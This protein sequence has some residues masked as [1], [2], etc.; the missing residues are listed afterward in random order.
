MSLR[1]IANWKLNG[2]KEF[3]QKWISNFFK[4]FNN[5]DFSSIGIAPPSMYLDHLRGLLGKNDICLGA[6]NIDEE[7]SG[8]RTGEISASMIKD[9][10]CEFSIVGHSERRTLFNESNQ[11]I[12]KKLIQANRYSLVPILCI[13][14]S[15]KEYQ[16]NITHE[17]LQQQILEGLNG[18][19]EICLLYTSPS[20]RD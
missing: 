18:C 4:Y 2:S 8:A 11:A 19:I 10:G 14:E 6:Q 13:G 17:I 12:S 7:D 16:D 15:I 1:L 3:N 20:P 9:L 5:H